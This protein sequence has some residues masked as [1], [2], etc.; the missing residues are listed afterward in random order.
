MPVADMFWGDRFGKLV[1]PFGHSW[2]IASHIEDVDPDEMM[3]RASAA[4]P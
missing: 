2:Q 1:D 3:K 4:M